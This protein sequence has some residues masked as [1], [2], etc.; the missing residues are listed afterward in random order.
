[1]K[2]ILYTIIIAIVLVVIWL[3]KEYFFWVMLSLIFLV[4]AVKDAFK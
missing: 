4:A 3:L 2:A 1:M